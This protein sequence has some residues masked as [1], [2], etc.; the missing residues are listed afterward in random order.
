MKLVKTIQV[1]ENNKGSTSLKTRVFYYV[2]NTPN[3][4]LKALTNSTSFILL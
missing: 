1:L 4:S 2:A 3:Y